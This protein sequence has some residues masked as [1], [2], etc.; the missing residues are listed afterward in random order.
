MRCS[1]HWGPVSLDEDAEEPLPGARA[2]S[3]PARPWAACLPGPEPACPDACQWDS[4]GARNASSGAAWLKGA[5]PCTMDTRHLSSIACLAA[6]TSGASLDTSIRS[7]GGSQLSWHVS[8]E[9][10]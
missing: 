1:S 2:P 9:E 10:S 7:H 4:G 6:T 8:C 5:G 3:L